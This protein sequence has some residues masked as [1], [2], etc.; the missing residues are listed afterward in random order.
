M[1]VVRPL[2]TIAVRDVNDFKDVGV[3]FAEYFAIF[4]QFKGGC[5]KHTSKYDVT[6][7]VLPLNNVHMQGLTRWPLDCELSIIQ[8]R[9]CSL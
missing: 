2:A 4:V 9:I 3:F 1:R 5:N 7:E 8:G 6:R